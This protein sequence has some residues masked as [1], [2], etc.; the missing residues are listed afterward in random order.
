[1]GTSAGGSFEIDSG[2]RYRYSKYIGWF[3]KRYDPSLSF[4]ASSASAS[5]IPHTSNA[6]W[7]M[8]PFVIATDH[9]SRSAAPRFG[10]RRNT[11]S[12]GCSP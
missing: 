11:Y 9:G 5:T 3:G 1:M 6:E 10:T 4:G 7:L 12:T 8:E 2:T